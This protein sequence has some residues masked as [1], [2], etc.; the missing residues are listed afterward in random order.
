M[1]V[2]CSYRLSATNRVPTSE[3]DYGVH[4]VLPVNFTRERTETERATEVALPCEV[5]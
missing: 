3:T 1:C 2:L 4:F 5:A